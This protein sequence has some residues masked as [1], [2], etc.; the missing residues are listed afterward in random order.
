MKQSFIFL[1]ALFISVVIPA[2][3]QS[4]PQESHPAGHARP[5]AAEPQHPPIISPEVHADRSVTFR[6]RDPNAKQVMLALE[7]SK[8]T[9]MQKGTGGVWTLTTAPLGPEFYGYTFVADGVSLLDPSNSLLKPN[10]L[11]LSSM[12]HV[13]GPASLPWEVNAVPHGVIH[14]HFYH[15]T[16]IGDNRDFYV[17]T[18]PGYHPTAR[19]RYP[20][21][22]LLH[23]YSDEANGW[24]AVGRANVIFD[25]LI[26]QGKMKP[27]IVVMTLG[28]GAPEIVSR[29]GPGFRDRK[30]RQENT[31]KYREALFT[32]VM[33]R[34]KKDYRVKTGRD[35][36]A[37]AGLSMGGGE[38]LDVGLNNLDRFAWI[39]SFSGA[40]GMGG[41]D[42]HQ[43]FPA[44]GSKDN[45]RIRLLWVAC[46][47]E[48]PLVGDMNRRFDRWLIARKIQFTEI[49]T[50]GV[51]SWM[52]WRD[53]LA[54]FAP[55]LFQ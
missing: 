42:L 46:G 10:L 41:R 48:D 21:F 44:L 33:P 30:L 9:P 20:V 38:S 24:I 12:V 5:H 11:H 53:N 50:P 17:Y 26:A 6:F 32:E 13:P 1:L 43:E 14:H 54:H 19:K 52:V 23:G 35:N 7:G 3:A 55:L 25:N 36:T 22:Y 40:V 8:P 28:Y 37:I 4:A 51:H 16:V 18:P 47:K 29:T 34:I 39:G 31:D 45:S 49:W 15:S 2:R 27:M